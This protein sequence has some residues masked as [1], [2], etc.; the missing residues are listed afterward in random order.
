MM[1]GNDAEIFTSKLKE[2]GAQTVHIGMVDAEGAFRHK[3]VHADKAVK[4]V[5]DG[6]SFCEVLQYWTLDEVP[7]RE[8]AFPDR[9]AFIDVNSL[10]SYPFTPDA[11]FCIADFDGEFGRCSSRNVL[12]RLLGQLA[13]DGLTLY[14]AFEFEF[15]LFAESRAQMAERGFT[16]PKS[17]APENRTYSLQTAAVYGDLI[18]G[19]KDT[20]TRLDVPLDALHSELGPGF[21]EAPLT[22]SKGLRGADNA[23]IFKNF[24]RAYFARNG[25]VAGFMAK[26]S[27]SLP[28]NSGHL[29]VSLRDAEG[30]PVF[31][32]PSDP[33]GITDTCRHFI[34]GVNLLLPEL[35]GM[36]AGT[37]NSYK[38]L[39][40]GTWAPTMPN[41]GVQ[42][43]TCAQ[44]VINDRPEATRVE[45]RVPAADANPYAT[46]A[47]C[48]GA[49]LYGIR[50]RI[51]P[52]APVE[53]NAY[54][55]P[56]DPAQVFPR[57]LGEAAERLAGSAR[58]CEIFG[59][60][61]V[62]TYAAMRREEN[63]AYQKHLNEISPWEINRYLGIV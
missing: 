41:W 56:C 22:Y 21:F 57:D 23:A 37:V 7:F 50:N 61:F 28:G 38:R 36:V 4:L 2:M 12:R 35:L 51:D 6:Y 44:R 13:D 29:H 9:P 20:M 8:T 59:E 39:I 25:I 53:G 11:A 40:P 52:G 15:N 43:R 55:R 19:L 63:A 5:R 10:R 27:Q 24:A 1:A 26:L 54:A 31:A 30:R 18:E 47:F 45:F 46:L 49:G 42:N 17:F 16:N 34:G 60:D 33:H 48:L 3:A 62:K 58:A 32:D 14:S